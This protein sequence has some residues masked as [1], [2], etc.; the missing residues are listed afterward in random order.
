[1]K[2]ALKVILKN[3]QAFDVAKAIGIVLLFFPLSSFALGLGKIE[4]SSFLN[5]NF[6]AKINLEGKVNANQNVVNV[7]LAPRNVFELLEVAYKPA[8]L[9]LNF[10]LENKLGALPYIRVWSK[11]PISDPYLTFILEYTSMGNS[12]SKKFTVLLD[13]KSYASN[14][15]SNFKT[16]RTVNVKSI[17]GPIGRN[18]TLWPLAKIHK[19]NDNVSVE[20]MMLALA[21]KNPNAFR[22]GNINVLLQGSKLIVPSIEEIIGINKQEARVEVSRQ[23]ADWKKS[24]GSLP[25]FEPDNGDKARLE[26]LEPQIEDLDETDVKTALLEEEVAVQAVQT[27]ELEDRLKQS[28]GVITLLKEESAVQLQQIQA[29]KLEIEKLN[30]ASVEVLADSSREKQSLFPVS[31]WVFLFFLVGILGLLYFSRIRKKGESPITEAISY[32]RSVESEPAQISKE[33]SGMVSNLKTQPG[34]EKHGQPDAVIAKKDPI[35]GLNVYLAY[36]RYEEAKQ[37]LE[38]AILDNPTESSYRIKLLTVLGEMGD[39][40]EFKAA[41]VAAEQIIGPSTTEWLDIKALGKSLEEKF[42]AH[43]AKVVNEEKKVDTETGG[44]FEEHDS[45]TDADDL[46]KDIDE[47]GRR[48]LPDPLTLEMDLDIDAEE[49]SVLSIRPIEDKKD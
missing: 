4:V 21:K 16:S 22:Q 1:M 45:T 41:A 17:I 35:A 27:A 48:S 11:G 36:E 10:S 49:D 14:K 9:N 26:L 20:Q 24:K 23:Y 3:R 43:S 39:L 33:V 47:Q 38:Q 2:G 46:E 34:D 15:K 31:A 6:E 8:L 28:E 44:D 5:E 12:M 13:P 42:S 19:P 30:N 25:R 37:M 18:D 7:G 32:P 40:E 29:L